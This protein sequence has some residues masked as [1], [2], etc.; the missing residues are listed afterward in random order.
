MEKNITVVLPCL[1][2]EKTISY[3]VEQALIGISNT[4]FEGQVLVADN[5]STDNSASLA[6]QAGAKVVS[7]NKKGYGAAL[8][9]GIKASRSKYIIMGDSDSTYNFLD[10]PLFIKKLE[11]GY[12][13]VVGNRFKGGIEKKAMPFLNKYLGNPFL[14]E[15]QAT[16]PANLVPLLHGCQQVVLGMSHAHP[17]AHAAT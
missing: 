11:E 6:K 12:D 3:C 16:E 14:I 1:N 7:I 15:L 10:I 17:H 5:G 13:L 8:N 9:G 2:E 4:K